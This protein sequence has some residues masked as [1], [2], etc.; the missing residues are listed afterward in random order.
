[1]DLAERTCLSVRKQTRMSGFSNRGGQRKRSI[2]T[3]SS[4]SYWF[5]LGLVVLVV[6]AF[7]VDHSVVPFWIGSALPCHKSNRVCEL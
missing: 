5:H 1:M 7:V 4:H 3:T 6:V 2:V